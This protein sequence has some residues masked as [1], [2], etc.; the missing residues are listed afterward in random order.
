METTAS[1]NHGPS[2]SPAR[3]GEAGF[4]LVEALCAIVILVFGLMAITN[5]MLVAASS[6][7]VANQSTAATT[8]AAQRMEILKRTPFATL[9]AG[10]DV[11]GSD[12]AFCEF[13][14]SPITG[15]TALQ[16]VGQIRTCWQISLVDPQT[17][18]IRVRSEGTGALTR[19]RSRAEFTAVRACTD[20]TGGLCPVGPPG[21]P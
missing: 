10:G 21:L 20:Q 6:N 12:P 14:T 13:A 5:L 11:A 16:G 19:A 1:P 3:R 4:T 7:T 8:A 9:A 17:F 18:F 15:L 2:A